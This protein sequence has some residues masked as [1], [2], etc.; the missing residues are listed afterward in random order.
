M[1]D[2]HTKSADEVYHYFKTDENTGLDDNQVKQ[3]QEKY[4]LN[5][6]YC[7]FGNMNM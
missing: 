5:G 6:E 4:G 1:D 2:S 7:E 3:N